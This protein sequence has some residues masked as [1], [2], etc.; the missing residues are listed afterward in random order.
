MRQTQWWIFPAFLAIALFTACGEIPQGDDESNQTLDRSSDE[1]ALTALIKCGGPNQAGCPDGQYCAHREGECA[2]TDAGVCKP[3]PQICT[4]EYAP[5]CGC[6]GKTYGNA[7]MAAAAGVSKLHAGPCKS[8]CVS[9]E[10]CSKGEFCDTPCDQD[11]GSCTPMISAVQ[12]PRIYKP[13]CG[14][15][16]KT[17]GN[18]CLRVSAQ[19]GL[20]HEGACKTICGGI[21]GIPCPKGQ[22]CI[23]ATDTCEWS[24]NQGQ[25]MNI[26]QV[27][28]TI[29]APVC[30]C[31]GKTYGNQC[32]ALAASMSIAHEGP[33]KTICEPIQ[34]LPGTLPV[35]EDGDG[36]D[37]ACIC[38]IAIDCIQ[39]W[40]P[41]DSN[42]DGCDDTCVP[43]CNTAC[44]CYQAGAQFQNGCFLKC[45][46]CGNFWSCEEGVCVE[47]C[48][49]MPPEVFQCKECKDNSQCGP[50]QFCQKDQGAC[51]AIGQCADKPEIC[52]SIWA[53]VCGCDGQTY[54]NDCAAAAAGVNVAYAGE[55]KQQGCKSNLDCAKGDYCQKQP[56]DCNGMGTC[57]KKPDACILIY[58]PVCGCDGQT[59]GNACGAAAAGVNV[60]YKGEC[61]SPC[62]PIQCS[63][64]QVAI[65]TD[66]DG[67][68]DTCEC[69]IA[70]KCA[71]GTVP[72]DTNGD[73]CDDSCKP[74]GCKNNLE[75]PKD[76]YC[77]KAAGD[78]E[79]F[80]K[81][82]PKPQACILIY[83]PVCGCDGKTYGN[84]CEA[85]AAGMNVAY[86]GLCESPCDPIKCSPE[87]IGID[88]DG[89]GCNDICECAFAIKCA[90][91]FI[92]VDTNGDGCHDACKP[93]C[94][95]LLCTSEQ[96]AVDSDGDGCND[97]CVCAFAILCAA[98]FTPIDTNGDGCM[99]ACKPICKVLQCTSEQAAVDADGDGCP[100]TCLCKIAIDCVP[101]YKPTDSNG[102]GCIDKCV[103]MCVELQCSPEK[104]P[105]DSNNDGCPDICKC[106]LQIT[107]PIGTK[108]ADSNGDGCADICAPAC[109]ILE[110]PAGKKPIDAD[111]NG[112]MDT[113]VC[114]T[115]IVCPTG[116]KPIDSNN[117]GCP[118]KCLTP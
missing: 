34:C 51:D 67:C 38:G 61:K 110:C 109:P 70:I 87:Q 64:E 53:P 90:P 9:D 8:G 88:T 37:D 14:C 76:A 108:P 19:V 31:D 41:A 39:G 29:W 55:C 69:A 97:Q 57:A 118:D 101:G 11:S 62:D 78:C 115:T 49:F 92:S 42:G 80:G 73:G 13:V 21:Q 32:E 46:N 85:A 12:C 10:Q 75:C 96:V 16:G 59:Y 45:M 93:L 106:A 114:D 113:C 95:D 86:K 116:S 5:V 4:K 7:C 54:S 81:C 26:P 22:A 28:P 52:T 100:D 17:Y 89:D 30:G 84:A 104:K 102:D 27:C 71:S 3:K 24:D 48:G 74:V 23:F 111:G 56:G 18:D 107:C 40:V 98:G 82:A 1:A 33:C 50:N 58:D 43:T 117:D 60:A 77:A 25:C 68:N 83:D 6:D 105:V 15:N 91:G 72:T 66:G 112:C 47:N 36:C 44:D 35:D 94:K 20:A 103:P 63:S 2:A 79:G 65:D 99:D